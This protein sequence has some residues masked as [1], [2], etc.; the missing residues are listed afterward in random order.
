[1]WNKC[2]KAFLALY[3]A[4]KQEGKINQKKYSS[5]LFNVIQIYFPQEMIPQHDLITQKA[6]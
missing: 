4:R 2:I 1:M 6:S 5:R 3:R